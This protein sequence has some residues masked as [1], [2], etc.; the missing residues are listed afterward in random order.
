[1]S[2]PTISCPA[3]DDKQPAPGGDE[4]FFAR[5]VAHCTNCSAR[6]AYGELAPRIIVQPGTVDTIDGPRSVFMIHFQD[7]KTR[8]DIHVEKLDPQYAFLLAQNII[9]L[10]RP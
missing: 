4:N 1:M 8:Q 10:V 6:I 9:S 3:C 5:N 2:E 7:P